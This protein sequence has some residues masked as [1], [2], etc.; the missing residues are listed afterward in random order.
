MLATGGFCEE[1]IL[2]V[3][4]RLLSVLTHEGKQ[5][6]SCGLHFDNLEI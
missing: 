3:D 1:L 2:A 6:T 5:E 4:S